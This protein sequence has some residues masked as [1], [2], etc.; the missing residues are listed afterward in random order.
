MSVEQGDSTG[1]QLAV[2]PL[3]SDGGTPLTVF[4]VGVALALLH[5][6]VLAIAPEP[7]PP[8]IAV[9]EGV[10]CLALVAVELFETR[11]L[12]R[13][14]AL[15]LAFGAIVGSCWLALWWGLSLWAVATALAVGA[16]LL[17]YSGH[18]YQLVTLGLVEENP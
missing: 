15:G 10:V 2:S 13:S 16:I 7:T 18:R 5:L 14:L 3:M 9:F 1:E 11:S 12:A 6:A 4:R 17:I 8:E